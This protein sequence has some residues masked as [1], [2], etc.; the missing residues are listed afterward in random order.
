MRRFAVG[1]ELLGVVDQ[2]ARLLRL[3]RGRAARLAAIR[4]ALALVA[5]T[6]P[7]GM[8][9]ALTLHEAGVYS[10]R[11]CETS[12]ARDGHQP[13]GTGNEYGCGLG[14]HASRSPAASCRSRPRRRGRRRPRGRRGVRGDSQAEAREARSESACPEALPRPT[15]SIRTSRGWLGSRRRTARSSTRSSPTCVRTGASPASSRSR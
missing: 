7:I 10:C 11:G 2:S 9:L 12:A 13:G 3:D 8:A 6:G 5:L 4:T 15:T 14:H 1:Q